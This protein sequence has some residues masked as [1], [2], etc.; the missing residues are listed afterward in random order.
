MF[1]ALMTAIYYVDRARMADASRWYEQVLGKPPY[2]DGG[3]HYVGFNVDGFELGL[4]PRDAEGD[5]AP[6]AGALPY[7]GVDDIQTSYQQLIALGASAL[8]A[9]NNVGGDIWVAEVRDP[10][11]CTLGLIQNPHFANAAP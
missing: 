1:K 10:F 4:H 11:G 3:E 2:F 6:H 9:P 7:W 8:Q 5:S